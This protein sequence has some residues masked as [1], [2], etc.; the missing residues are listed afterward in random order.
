M[1]GSKYNLKDFKNMAHALE[2]EFKNHQDVTKLTKKL[3]SMCANRGVSTAE[4][5]TMTPEVIHILN[6]IWNVKHSSKQTVVNT[7]AKHADPTVPL[8]LTPDDKKG[9][10]IVNDMNHQHDV[11][12]AQNKQLVSQVYSK[13]KPLVT[14]INKNYN[15][16]FEVW[17]KMKVMETRY[18]R[19]YRAYYAIKNK[20]NYTES[21]KKK[22]QDMYHE[23]SS[24][25]IPE[26]KKLNNA[27]DQLAVHR[28][29]LVE[30]FYS[31]YQQVP[32][33]QRGNITLP[34]T[35]F[36]VQKKISHQVNANQKPK[37]NV[38]KC[39]QKSWKD[40][41]TAGFNP[42]F[43]APCHIARQNELISHCNSKF[44]WPYIAYS[45]NM[46]QPWDPSQNYAEWMKTCMTIEHHE[47]PYIGV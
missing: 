10:H 4:C 21:D 29:Q 23:I 14:D 28:S 1:S 26:F 24:V 37:V 40:A 36:E 6:Q 47:R 41:M 2:S 20:T 9:M 39:I 42:T 12:T 5:N 46:Y 8:H 7:I 32:A 17:N 38:T 30:K 27:L 25:I 3:M 35:A 31:L 16:Y 19:D 43:Y 34:T 45:S 44:D 33:E 13:A 15:D 11:F 22:L 18:I